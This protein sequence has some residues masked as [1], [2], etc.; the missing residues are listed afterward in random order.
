MNRTETHLLRALIPTFVALLFC[1]P[2]NA[3]SQQPEAQ[4]SYRAEVFANSP[5]ES[6]LRYLQVEGKVPL[7]PWS[8]RT[9]SARE[10]DRLIPADSVSHPW[11]SRLRNESR[12]IDLVGIGKV[13]YGIIQPSMSTR[14]NSSFAYG[15][16]DGALWAGRGLTSAAQLGFYARWRP[17]T[18]TVAPLVF[19]SANQSY[20]IIPNGRTGDAAFGDPVFGGVDRPQRFGDTPYSQIDPGQTTLRVDLP[21]VAVGAST[22]NQAW[23]PAQ[24]LPVILGNNAAGFPH[25]FAG[26]SA[27]VNIIIGKLQAKVIWGELTQS[28][29]SPV[30]GSERYVSRAEPGTKRFATGLVVTGQPRGLPGLEIGGARFFHS[31]WPQSGIPRSYFTKFL[32]GFIKKN[33]APDRLA[34]PRFPGGG[35]DD[36]GISDNQLVSVFGRWVLPHSG[37]ELH[38]EYGRDDHSYDLRDLTQEPDHARVYTL[39]ARKVFQSRSDN[40]TAG[41]FE[42]MNFQLPQL[43]RYRGEGEI[44]VHGLI[45]QGH[46]NKGQMLGAD[47]GVGTGAGSV[48]AVDRFTPTG[49]WTASW[50]RVVRRENGDYLVLGV[51]SPRSMDVSHALGFET[52]RF[53]N[54]FDVDAGVT[55][56]HEFNRDFKRDANN[57]NAL[58]GVRYLLR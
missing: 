37:F 47:V 30:V 33:I 46:T 5:A 55:L 28:D 42:V 41:R 18:L 26:T 56:V 15:S 45:R 36:R 17:V 2:S 10:L 54:G 1:L 32:Q 53:M 44:Y 11:R 35:L 20:A 13:Q 19:R 51:R 34:D 43:S 48:M 24:E 38:A 27:P 6:Y 14:Y 3:E 58:V 7:Y 4:G 29:Y 50:S 9:F 57:L 40:L 52:T 22:A 25:L 12:S 49:R 21:F 39:G 16:N 23:G 31:I 8:S